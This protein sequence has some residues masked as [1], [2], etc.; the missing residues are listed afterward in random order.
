M[1]RKDNSL[2]NELILSYKKDSFNKLILIKDR[3]C[4]YALSILFY[5]FV[6]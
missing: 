6:K 5:L 3:Q 2:I 1:K 4:S